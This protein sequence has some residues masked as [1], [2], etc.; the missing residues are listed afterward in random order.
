MSGMYTIEL[1]SAC[2]I[3]TKEGTANFAGMITIASIFVFL[4]IVYRIKLMLKALR[5]LFMM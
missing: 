4:D 3:G 5:L 1:G 2:K